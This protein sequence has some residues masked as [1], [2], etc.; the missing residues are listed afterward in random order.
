VL[1]A[2]GGLALFGFLADFFGTFA[3]ASVTLA[4]PVIPLSLLYLLLPETRGVE[5]DSTPHLGAPPYQ[6]L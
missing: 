6:Q 3:T 2:V 4:A 1:G 5:L